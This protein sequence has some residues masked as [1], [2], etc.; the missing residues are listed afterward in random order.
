MAGVEHEDAFSGTELI[1][2]L[3]TEQKDGSP[4]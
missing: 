4:A 3:N 2:D 1:A